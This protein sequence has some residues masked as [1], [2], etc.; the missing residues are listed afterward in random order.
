LVAGTLAAVAIGGCHDEAAT[1]PEITGVQLAKSKSQDP[2]VTGTDP[3]GAPQDT[4]LDVEVSGSGFDNGSTVELK[5]SGVPTEKVRT[6]STRYRNPRT[7]IANITIAADAQIDFYDVEVTT[8]R[9]KKGIGTEMFE[10]FVRGGDRGA[11]NTLLVEIRGTPSGELEGFFG[12][13]TP[14]FVSEMQEVVG[15]FDDNRIET[16]FSPFT[17]TLEPLDR[18]YD[19]WVANA[20]ACET[21]FLETILTAAAEGSLNVKGD[22]GVAEGSLKLYAEWDLRQ[23]FSSV[24]AW[25]RVAVGDDEYEIRTPQA[26]SP[27]EDHRILRPTA[28]QATVALTTGHFDIRWRKLGT[29]GTWWGIERC[30]VSPTRQPQGPMDFEVWVSK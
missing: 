13:A 23:G 19:G 15:K 29:K 24:F 22:P 16:K 6:N 1:E 12:E 21:G 9:G 10:V 17:L 20:E 18:F 28:T 2:E 14:D 5:L 8:F 11:G 3:T 27:G 7:L 30:F 26:G 4:T 25:F